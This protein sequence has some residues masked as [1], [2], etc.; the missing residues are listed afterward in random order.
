VMRALG[1]AP[2]A[3][4]MELLARRIPLR[5]LR[6]CAE[7]IDAEALLL[8][9]AGLLNPLEDLPPGDDATR[10]YAT[11]LLQR[12]ESSPE[13]A[14]PRMRSDAWQFAR[15][16]PANAPA[17]RIAQAAALVTPGG[18]LHCDPLPLL[19]DALS[20]SRPITVLRSL[21]SETEADPFW[22]THIRPGTRC[23]DSSAAIGRTRADDIIV[24]AIIP[25]LLLAAGRDQDH[26][27]ADRA[28]DLL[29]EL[30]PGDDRVTR[31]FAEYGPLATDALEAQGLHH[32]LKTRC[33]KGRC[34]SCTVGRWLLEH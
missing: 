29:L 19:H 2:N 16:R 31:L 11:A 28:V 26:E 15:L 23:R 24:N 33:G 14:A 27:M 7:R 5:R 3:E 6:R 32:L 12:F 13:A 8:G 18:L 21:L 25:T 1:F 4:A 10:D 9:A 34:L 20:L 30:P 17:R 22:R